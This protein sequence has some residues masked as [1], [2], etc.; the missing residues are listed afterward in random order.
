MN[1]TS[2]TT[3]AAGESNGIGPSAG[4]TLPDA[5]LENIDRGIAA[6]PPAKQ[7]EAIAELEAMLAA[8]KS[9]AEKAGTAPPAAAASAP[10]VQPAQAPATSR[11]PITIDPYPDPPHMVESR[12]IAYLWSQEAIEKSA[13]LVAIDDWKRAHPTL[14]VEDF[15]YLVVGDKIK[16]F[17]PLDGYLLEADGGG[18]SGMPVVFKWLAQQP[19]LVAAASG[20]IVESKG[21][22]NV[23]V[24]ACHSLHKLIP[25][26]QFD[27]VIHGRVRPMGWHTSLA[28]EREWMFQ[29]WVEPDDADPRKP[30]LIS[31]ES[32]LGKSSR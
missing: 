9:A 18:D 6:M 16:R 21:P 23:V 20:K 4:V 25:L 17:R 7:K 3:T 26:L 28:N 30:K 1:E 2:A 27:G 12:E 22:T 8:T 11:A 15:R 24:H 32:A 13:Y 29:L 10:A 14:D 19:L 31:L 5:V